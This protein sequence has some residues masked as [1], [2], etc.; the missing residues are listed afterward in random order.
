VTSRPPAEAVAALSTAARR[1]RLAGFEQT[2]SQT[3]FRAAAFGSPFDGVLE[4]RAEPLGGDGQTVLRFSARLKPLM[5]I[6]AAAI[7]LATIWPGVMLTE[8]LIASFFPTSSAWQYTWWWYMPLSVPFVP[9]AYW[10]A[11]KRSRASVRES[12]LEVIG[13]IAKE[14]GGRLD[15]IAGPTTESPPAQ[16][17]NPTGEA[18][19]V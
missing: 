18:K 14:V 8:S 2:G 9:W 5:P 15:P 10:V 17:A 12:A 4:G 11:L 13:K 1:G 6:I 16:A 7:F 3:A 19:A